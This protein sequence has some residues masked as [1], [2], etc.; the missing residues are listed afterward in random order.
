MSAAR[1][2]AAAKKLSR[3]ARRAK[4]SRGRQSERDLLP[5]LLASGK[6][7]WEQA[8]G[9]DSDY[10]PAAPGECAPTDLSMLTTFEMRGT[11]AAIRRAAARASLASPAEAILLW[12]DPE[13]DQV[14]AEHAVVPFSWSLGSGDPDWLPPDMDEETWREFAELVGARVFSAGYRRWI[15]TRRAQYDHLCVLYPASSEGEPHRLT[16]NLLAGGFFPRPL[17]ATTVR[18]EV[19]DGPAC[20]AWSVA[21]EEGEDEVVARLVWRP[22]GEEEQRRRR[23]RVERFDEAI[24]GVLDAFRVK[25]GRDRRGNTVVHT[26][27][28]LLRSLGVERV[29]AP[30]EIEAGAVLEGGT[31]WRAPGEDDL[32]LQ[33]W[34]TP[35]G[36]RAARA[37]LVDPLSRPDLPFEPVVES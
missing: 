15:Q 8:I 32:L 5:V 14:C 27:A 3:P 10:P 11:P 25:T 28:Q 4:A 19:L 12:P 37:V 36:E 22:I 17:V 31:G 1:A 9:A 16:E 21:P 23:A 2:K 18:Q 24:A 13:G 30:G 6:W 20:R 35:S 26:L 33:V 34:R 29:L 7:W